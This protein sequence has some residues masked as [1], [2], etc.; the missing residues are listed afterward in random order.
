MLISQLMITPLRI[1][2]AW[3]YVRLRPADA[4]GRG[5]GVFD[6]FVLLLGICL[7]AFAYRW[8]GT[9]AVNGYPADWLPVYSTLTTFIIF[10]MLLSLGWWVRSSLFQG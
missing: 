10:P 6:G 5:I 2:F 4:R 1:L 8:V 9:L 7:C 3:G